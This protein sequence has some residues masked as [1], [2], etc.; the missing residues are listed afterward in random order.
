MTLNRQLSRLVPMARQGRHHRAEA[1][2]PMPRHRAA[3]RLGLAAAVTAAGL[4]AAQIVFAAPPVADFTISDSVPEVGQDVSFSASVTDP[5]AGDTHTFAWNFG[6]GQSGSGQTPLHSFSSPGTKT[7]TL[8]VTDSPGGESTTVT[9]TLRVNAPPTAAVNCSPA[10]PAPNDP[11]ACS[12]SGSSD[13]EGGLSYAWD[14]DGDG[15][16]DGSDSSETFY[17]PTAGTFNIRL[18]VTDSDGATDIAQ[19]GVTVANAAP[20]ATITAITPLDPQNGNL[21]YVGQQIRFEGTGTDPNGDNLSFT[22]NFGTGEGTAGGPSVTHAFGSHGA[23]TVTLTVSDGTDT[24]TDTEQVTI[25]AL[26][27]ARAGVLNAAREEGQRNDVPLVG[28]AFALTAGPIPAFP[29]A[30][31]S[32]GATDADGTNGKPEQWRWDLDNNGTFGDATGES[33]PFGP[34]DTPGPRT[35]GLEV[36]DSRQ[37]T[38]R[39]T[40]EFFVNSAPTPSFIIEPLKPIVDELVTFTSN[41]T[42]A[43]D[44]AGQLTY[45]WDLDDDGNFGEADERGPSVTHRFPTANL[46]PGH[47]VRLRVT[48]TGGV[49]RETTR[50][51]MV[52]NTRPNA[53]PTPLLSGVLVEL[54]AAVYPRYTKVR[55]L[56]VR[57]PKGSKITV[58]CKGKGCPK[59]ITKTAKGSKKL[60]FKK[61]QRKFK[62]GRKLIVTVTKNGFIGRQTRWTIRRRKAPLRQD[63]CM[64][65]GAKKAS[66]CRGG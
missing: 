37:A 58:R 43:Q 44:N 21:P 11:I 57:A 41:S 12:G 19:R 29:P 7:V 36:V 40:L 22:W 66:S 45:N 9:K 35:V 30:P 62:P 24:G 13:E 59:L 32:P 28:Q 63:L 34:F 4:V 38:S 1:E 52:Q 48:D 27:V 20:T 50:M 17:F 49:T 53:G 31:A 42:D 15:F 8:T 33:V 61:L 26:P 54:R 18:R 6:D 23:K 2:R 64:T 5:D 55:G 16:D 46:S 51:V 14:K 39:T 60:R 56:L 10:N 65:P 25:N 3:R 47:R